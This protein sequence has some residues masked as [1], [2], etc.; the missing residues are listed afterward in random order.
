MAGVFELVDVRPD[1]RLPGLVVSR[2]VA[3][4]GAPGMQADRGCF[5]Q[6]RARQLDENAADFLNLLVL[7][8]HVLI[9]E[10]VTESQLAGF[11]FRLG[12]GVERAIL[13]PQ[14]LGRIAGHPEGF[15][16]VH[17]C[18]AH[19]LR[20]RLETAGEPALLGR[21]HQCNLQAD[22]KYEEASVF[23]MPYRPCLKQ[24]TALSA[25]VLRQMYRRA[26]RAAETC[27]GCEV[28]CALACGGA[29]RRE[30]WPFPFFQPILAPVA[31]HVHG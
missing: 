16:V 26:A 21:L 23:S 18:P 5:R 2:G 4:S 3:A 28:R 17:S 12:T 25:N 30:G 14:L 11:G 7:I 29:A 19:G 31:G 9:A 20:S 24:L 6:N 27:I 8:K 22:R 1:F 10:Q 15:F 13:R